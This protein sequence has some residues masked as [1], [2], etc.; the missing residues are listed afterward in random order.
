VVDPVEPE[1]PKESVASISDL[2]VS[3][4]QCN[5]VLLSWSDVNTED[6]YRVRRRI[7]G[8]S[9]EILTDLAAN[10]QSYVDTQVD[11]GVT[12]EYMV[13]PMQNGVAVAVSNV[14]SVSVPQ[15]PVA[16]EPE[17]T[18]ISTACED[19]SGTITFTFVDNPGRT[20]IAFSIDAGNT[21]TSVPDQNGSYTFG[22]LANGVYDLWTQWGNGDS[23]T[24]LE[25]VELSCKTFVVEPEPIPVPESE[26]PEE[27]TEPEPPVVEEGPVQNLAVVPQMVK[28][29]GELHFSV[30]DASLRLGVEIFNSQGSKVRDFSVQNLH[31]GNNQIWIKDS[32][33]LHTGV[34]VVK[35]SVSGV[36]VATTTFSKGR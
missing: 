8:G 26:V 22:G 16:N 19:G 33:Q 10:A 20:H 32:H 4:V 9:Y 2:T 15:C 6:A 14:P 35:V 17:I 23:P 1:N 5:E 29:Y 3:A 27:P 25:D 21:F 24:D 30:H 28:D 11:P 31:V 7:P 13:R 34:Y 12:Y 18:N 36:V